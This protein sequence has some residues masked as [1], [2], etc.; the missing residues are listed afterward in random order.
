MRSADRD[1]A[2]REC[3]IKLPIGLP[4]LPEDEGIDDE[5]LRTLVGDIRG[6]RYGSIHSLLVARHGRLVVE[7][8]FDGWAASQPHTQQSDTTSVLS[9][10]TGL[11]VERSRLRLDDKVLS[12]FPAYQPVASLDAFKQ[13]L[14]V[15]DLLTMRTGLDGS[16]AVSAGSA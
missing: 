1:D 2:T 6:H 4:A 8:Y 12:F 15:A 10:V 7:E 16:E 5:T 3:R 9:L 13:S 11:A 14:T